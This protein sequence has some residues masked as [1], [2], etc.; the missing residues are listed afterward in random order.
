MG[1]REVALAYLSQTI[2]RLRLFLLFVL[3]VTALVT[4]TIGGA[5]GVYVGLVAILVSLIFMPDVKYL[6]YALGD[7]G[8]RAFL[9]AFLLLCASFMLS[10]R[11]ADDPMAFVDF[12][13]LPLVVPAYALVARHSSLVRVELISRLAMLGCLISLA[14][15]LV[16]VHIF[17]MARAQGDT[18]S[19]FFADISALLGFFCLVGFTVERTKWRWLYVLGHAAGLAACLAGGSRGALLGYAVLYGCFG[20]FTLMRGEGTLRKRVLVLAAIPILS[21]GLGQV[22]FSTERVFTV[23]SV[24]GEVAST[25]K[26]DTDESATHRLAFWQGGLGA[27]QQSPI[28]GNGWWRRYD[29]AV[30]YMPDDGVD[31]TWSDDTSHL[32]NDLINFASAAG[33]LGVA[34]YLLLIAGPA[35]S[36][37]R[38]PDSPSR[39]FRLLAAVG[40]SFGYFIFGM[41][42]TMFVFEVPKSLFVL[43]AAVIMACM[44]ELPSRTEPVPPA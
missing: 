24:L 1:E 19:I 13:A 20:V 16:Q 22:L 2:S 15:A 5:I 33:I 31:R 28:Y 10:A 9:A 35:I 44:S 21:L 4:P 37:W 12:L 38:A 41:T 30:P 18:V 8:V 42:D 17:G 43:C 6:A 11:N 3:L 27:F 26:A 25:G 7:W 39:S 34:A 29:A 40:L 32:H 36:A 23:V 14:A